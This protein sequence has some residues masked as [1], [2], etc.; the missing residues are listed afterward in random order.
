MDARFL[1][2]AALVCALGLAFWLLTR[3]SRSRRLERAPG[4]DPADFPKGT[5]QDAP[6][7]QATQDPYRSTE[8]ASG[9]DA[10]LARLAAQGERRVQAQ[11]IARSNQREWVRLERLCD[12]MQLL[13]PAPPGGA[14]PT[15]AE[16]P[17]PPDHAYQDDY[18]KAPDPAVLQAAARKAYAERAW[19]A[20]LPF[21]VER[22]FDVL[23]EAPEAIFGLEVTVALVDASH[24]PSL[25]ILRGIVHVHDVDAEVVLSRG[26]GIAIE[27]GS[28][29][30]ALPGYYP[31]TVQKIAP[32]VHGLVDKA[33]LPLHRSHAIARV[34]L[35]RAR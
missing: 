16:F 27:V 29:A 35:T 7:D 1:L 23:A 30:I 17:A 4:V 32:Y 20:S 22:Y 18:A 3:R 6:A 13:P 11:A 31:Y 8:E 19:L 12:A 26:G 28:A 2:G 33:L 25:E 10:E 21:H 15:E 14:I 34:T 24:T 9:P 5:P